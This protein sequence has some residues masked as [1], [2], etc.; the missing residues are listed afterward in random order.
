MLGVARAALAELAQ[1][2]EGD[3]QRGRE[4]DERDQEEDRRLEAPRLGLQPLERR[5]APTKPALVERVRRQAPFLSERTISSKAARC[6][7][8]VFAGPVSLKNQLASGPW[9]TAPTSM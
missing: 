4:G 2:G 5:E 1:L 3:D 7:S 6:A 9:A 8:T